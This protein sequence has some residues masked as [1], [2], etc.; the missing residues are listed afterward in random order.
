MSIIALLDDS[1]RVIEINGDFDKNLI[2]KKVIIGSYFYE[3]F[4]LNDQKGIM[5]ICKNF[6]KNNPKM[7]TFHRKSIRFN[8][9]TN[10]IPYLFLFNW[11]LV[12]HPNGF[13]AITYDNKDNTINPEAE[14]LRDYFDRAPIALHWLSSKGIILWANKRELDVLGYS[15]DEYIGQDIMKFCPDSKEEVLEIFKQLGSGNTI[16][17]VPIRFRKKNGK[18]QDL[19]ID[20]NVNYTEDG[21]FNH[22]RCFIRDDTARMIREAK[23]K[24]EIESQLVIARD[25]AKFLSMMIHTLKTPV[26]ILTMMT[27]DNDNDNNTIKHQSN[28]LSSIISSV[29]KAMKFDDGYTIKNVPSMCNLYNFV[30]KLVIH[31]SNSLTNHVDFYCNCSGVILLIDA[32]ILNTILRELLLYADNR[33]HSGGIIKIFINLNNDEVEF[34]V[35]D[36]GIKLD[37]YMVEKVFHNYW[38]NCVEKSDVQS[39]DVC[40]NVAFNCVESIDSQL[41]VVSDDKTTQFIFKIKTTILEQIKR[42]DSYAEESLSDF[43]SEKLGNL[44]WD[45]IVENLESNVLSNS[46]HILI[47]EDNSISQ[48]ICKKLVNKLGHTCATADNGQIAVEMV[49]E[50]SVNIYDLIFMDIRMPVMD[51]LEAA[52]Q[53]KQIY[54]DLPIIPLTAEEYSNEFIESGMISYMSKPSNISDIEYHINKY[55]KPCQIFK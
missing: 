48:I 36:R 46:K 47:V 14:E 34:I 45:R 37:E 20:S 38:L 42:E 12:K 31:I 15:K 55:S 21:S 18:I 41:R 54:P 28:I 22:T 32:N 29:S 10:E 7:T 17:D 23:T 35:E 3:I 26:H 27:S 5:K 1:F 39:F 51:G 11:T 43:V 30:Q 19:L 6:Q 8:C 49:K 2:P 50:C 16:H 4:Q 33:T 9:G 40:L 53:I 13:T 24:I 52:K 25:K 44:N